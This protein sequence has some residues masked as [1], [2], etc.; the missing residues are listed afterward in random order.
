VWRDGP[1]FRGFALG[2]F[3]KLKQVVIDAGLQER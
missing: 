3:A 1:S 2:E